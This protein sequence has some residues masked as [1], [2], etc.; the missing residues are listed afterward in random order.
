MWHQ[1]WHNKLYLFL[2]LQLK[3]LLLCFWYTDT[4]FA[5][6]SFSICHNKSRGLQSLFNKLWLSVWGSKIIHL[7][8]YLWCSLN[9]S[10]LYQSTSSLISGI[11]FVTLTPTKFIYLQIRCRKKHS[12]FSIK[13]KVFLEIFVYVHRWRKLCGFLFKKQT[14]PEAIEIAAVHN[15]NNVSS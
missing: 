5:H 3:I 7:C 11:L 8:C 10:F 2:H 14:N 15:H 13:Y 6:H 4:I 1:K 12:W 9:F